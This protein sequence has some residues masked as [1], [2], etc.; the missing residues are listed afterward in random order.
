MRAAL[1]RQTGGPEVI[2]IGDVDRPEPRAG[3]VRIG[4][5]AAA[6]NHLDLFVRRGIPGVELELPH[7][8]GSDAAGVVDAVGHGVDGW[9]PGTGVVV[10]PS[11]PCLR[12]AYCRAG[13]TP[14]CD[15]YRVL[16]EHTQGS[17]AEYLVVRADRLYPKPAHLNWA[18][19]AAVPLVFQT[20]WRALITR[21]AVRPGETVVILGAGGGVA[22]AAIQIARLAGARVIAVTSTPERAQLAHALG[23]DVTVDRSAGSWSRAV[24]DATARRGADV[25]V[26]SV[27]EATWP[28]TIRTVSRGG[29]IVTFGA[30]TGPAAK[31]D[32]R[33]VFWR[34]ITILGTTMATDAEFAAVMALVDRGRLAPVVG[35]VLPLEDAGRAH[36]LLES[37][38]VAGKVVL[39]LPGSEG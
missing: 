39:V 1:F 4:V 15:T 25:I 6:L 27:G 7:V 34:Q 26:D 24:W 9:A 18:E 20:A 13:Q 5:R 3:E 10:N 8:T 37:G 16:G 19:A 11:L 29:R 33:Y 28:D 35:A 31:T 30:T 23:A 38:A 17:V 36:A 32:L 22:T 21:A 2:E 12:C 14:L